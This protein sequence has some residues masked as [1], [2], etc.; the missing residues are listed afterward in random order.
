MF[1]LDIQ[2]VVLSSPRRSLYFRGD[3]VVFSSVQHFFCY[4]I[5][6]R[7]IDVSFWSNKYTNLPLDER[8][9]NYPAPSIEGDTVNGAESVDFLW[10]VRV[11]EREMEEENFTNLVHR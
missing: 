1:N 5:H 4:C 3:S 7:K 2:T 6:Y 11:E 10:T 8:Q 9:T